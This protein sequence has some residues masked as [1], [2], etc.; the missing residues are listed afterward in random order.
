MGHGTRIT[1]QL[2]ENDRQQIDEVL[3]SAPLAAKHRV[4]R[5]ALRLGL[6]EL[7]SEPARIVSCIQKEGGAR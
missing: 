1:I 7:L 5:T 3:L 2:D 4:V 6:R